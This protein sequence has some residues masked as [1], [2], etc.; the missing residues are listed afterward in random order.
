MADRSIAVGGR[1]RSVR[2][3]A[4]LTLEALAERADIDPT[5]LGG[6]ERGQ[7]NPTVSTVQRLARA[8][9]IEPGAL[10]DETDSFSRTTLEKRVAVRLKGMNEA[11]LRRALRVLDALR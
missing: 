2:K 5:Y 7:H 1:I 6:V 11:E 4:K 8:L 9:G 3:G 10:L